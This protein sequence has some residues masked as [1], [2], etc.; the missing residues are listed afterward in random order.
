[1]G[2][3]ASHQTITPPMPGTVPSTPSDKA[4]ARVLADTGQSFSIFPNAEIRTGCVIPGAVAL[5]IKGACETRVG[6]RVSPRGRSI[7]TVTFTEFW[8]AS[9]F[10]THGPPTGT[11]HHS[12]RFEIRAN[13]RIV[14]NGGG[15][16]VPPQ[17]TD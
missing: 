17:A 14:S 10:R 13:G 15:G 8:P 12:W 16:N 2:C 6:H 1:M 5:A 7:T 11:L 9:K 3:G 4:I